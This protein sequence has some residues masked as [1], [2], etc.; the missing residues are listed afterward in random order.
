MDSSDRQPLQGTPVT[1]QI[2]ARHSNRLGAVYSSLYSFWVS[3]LSA[4]ASGQGQALVRRDAYS[5]I[6][7]DHAVIKCL[8]NDFMG[9]PDVLL[10]AVLQYRAGGGTNYSLA[11]RSAQEVMERHWSTDRQAVLLLF[12]RSNLYFSQGP[13]CNFFIRWRM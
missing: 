9:S 13:S 6:L 5:V 1:G 10:N 4:L 3:R 12:L 2:A 7:F 8:E 11:I